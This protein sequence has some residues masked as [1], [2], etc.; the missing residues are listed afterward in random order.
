[1]TIFVVSWGKIIDQMALLSYFATVIIWLFQ[2]ISRELDKHQLQ[3]VGVSTLC[4]LLLVVPGLSGVAFASSSQAT[5]SGTARLHVVLANGGGQMSLTVPFSVKVTSGGA[6]VG[7]LF[8]TL[9]PGLPPPFPSKVTVGGFVATGSISVTEDKASGGGTIA[10]PQASQDGFGV[11]MN[12]GQFQCQNAGFSALSSLGITQMDVHG[13]V[14]PG[15]LV[16]S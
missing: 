10:P 3:L 16:V 6:G 12:G 7:T 13:T 4:L 14:T 5:F 8:L 2:R 9:G 11:T 15:S 1:M